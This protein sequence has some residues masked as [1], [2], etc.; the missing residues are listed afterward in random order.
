[1]INSINETIM[2]KRDSVDN[3]KETAAFNKRQQNKKVIDEIVKV[4]ANNN[5]EIS[6]AKRL[7]LTTCR[8]LEKQIVKF[9]D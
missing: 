1:M 7:L 5:L 8:Y 4:L 9:R 3:K 6:E 2:P